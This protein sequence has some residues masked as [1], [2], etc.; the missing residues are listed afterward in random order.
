MAAWLKASPGLPCTA[1]NAHRQCR[2]RMTPCKPAGCISVR[3][4]YPHPSTMARWGLSACPSSSPAPD[5]S[6]APSRTRKISQPLPRFHRLLCRHS[7]SPV[8][9]MKISAL[10]HP[11]SFSFSAA[12]IISCQVSRMWSSR[13]VHLD[14][15]TMPFVGSRIAMI[16]ARAKSRHLPISASETPPQSALQIPRATRSIISLTPF[17]SHPQCPGEILGLKGHPGSAPCRSS[18]S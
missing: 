6:L 17:S 9:G 14:I 1:R 16:A 11:R 15:S 5:C 18:A 13:Q 8:A 3:R 12:S 2:G 10:C 7:G 4:P